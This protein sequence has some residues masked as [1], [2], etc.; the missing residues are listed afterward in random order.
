MVNGLMEIDLLSADVVRVRY[1]SLNAFE[2]KQSLVVM[3][4]ATPQ[5]PAIYGAG[6]GR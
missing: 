4:S 1:T 3:V 5:K 6:A 2:P